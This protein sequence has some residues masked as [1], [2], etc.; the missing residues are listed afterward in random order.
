MDLLDD[1]KY[2][3]DR[4]G[5]IKKLI[6]EWKPINCETEKDY[7]NSLYNFLHLNLPNTQITK[8][9]AKGRIKADIVIDEKYIVELKNKLNSRNNYQRLIGQLFEYKKWEGSI[10]LL[11]IGEVDQNFIKEIKSFIKNE[12]NSFL[13]EDPKY[14]LIEKK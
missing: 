3:F 7:E 10:I 14:I 4:L 1:I 6:E 9:F 5:Y 12:D 13:T 11:L 8:Q 2:K